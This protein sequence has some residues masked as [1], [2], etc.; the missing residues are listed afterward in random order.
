MGAGLALR[1]AGTRPD[2]IAAAA[3]FHGA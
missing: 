2:R 1:T 3:G